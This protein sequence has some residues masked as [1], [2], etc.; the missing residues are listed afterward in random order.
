MDSESPPVVQRTI[1]L[2]VEHWM[3]ADQIES[4]STGRREKAVVDSVDS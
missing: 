2:L 1:Q 3:L 4:Q